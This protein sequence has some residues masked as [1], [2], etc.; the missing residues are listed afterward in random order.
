MWTWLWQFLVWL[1]LMSSSWV[2]WRECQQSWQENG[3]KDMWK[4]GKAQV[5]TLMGGN[6]QDHALGLMSDV[7]GVAAPNGSAVFLWDRSCTSSPKRRLISMLL[8]GR[9]TSPQLA[10]AERMM[11]IPGLP[12]L[13]ALLKLPRA[14]HLQK[15]RSQKVRGCFSGTGA[16]QCLGQDGFGSLSSVRCSKIPW[17]LSWACQG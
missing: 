10:A 8:L 16:S 4:E 13:T 9:K 5:T 1:P 12:H 17:Q 3:Y 15:P 6:N 11:E 14:S 7:R 2:E